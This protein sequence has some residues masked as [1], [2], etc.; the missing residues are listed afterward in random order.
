MDGMTM[1]E[2]MEQESNLDSNGILLF[3]E[4][5]HLL[6]ERLERLDRKLERVERILSKLGKVVL[7][8]VADDSEAEE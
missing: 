2:A 3:S 5:D 1:T 4:E 7:K 8:H 6:M